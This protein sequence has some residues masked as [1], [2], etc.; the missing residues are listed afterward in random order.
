MISIVRRFCLVRHHGES[1]ITWVDSITGA[2][3]IPAL[4]PGP[5][6]VKTTQ[7]L[8][9]WWGRVKQIVNLH[10]H[11]TWSS[12]GQPRHQN[13]QSGTYRSSSEQILYSCPTE[14]GKKNFSLHRTTLSRMQLTNV[15]SSLENTKSSGK[16][17][18][19]RIG[20]LYSGI[21]RGSLWESSWSF[22]HCFLH[23]RS[24]SVKAPVNLCLSLWKGPWMD[25]GFD[26]GSIFRLN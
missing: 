19:R 2:V 1:G 12:N 15:D 14:N 16:R 4:L 10:E 8:I 25:I 17:Y 18:A 26:V 7:M 6:L 11:C 13:Q 21:G 23:L 9:W 24:S 20:F 3:S 22:N 5:V